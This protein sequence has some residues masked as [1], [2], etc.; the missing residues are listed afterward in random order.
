MLRLALPTIAVQV[1]QTIV[2][3]NFAGQGFGKMLWPFLGGFIRLVVAAGIG[4]FA[5]TALTRQRRTEAGHAAPGKAVIRMPSAR[6]LRQGAARLSRTTA[7]V[8]D[9]SPTECRR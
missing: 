4:R 1:A 2:G 7:K 5:V 6:G 9:D 3:M 8:P